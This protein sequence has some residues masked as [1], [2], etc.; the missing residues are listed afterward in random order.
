[1]ASS[2][3]EM[4]LWTPCKRVVTVESNGKSVE[5]VLDGEQTFRFLVPKEHEVE[6]CKFFEQAG[7]YNFLRNR[8]SFSSFEA[9]RE[10]VNWVMKTYI[11]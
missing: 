11:L 10:A 5:L 7:H 9:L 6:I 1:M 3:V 2:M 4:N 8:Y